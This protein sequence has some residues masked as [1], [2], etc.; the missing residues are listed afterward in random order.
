MGKYRKELTKQSYNIEDKSLFKQ[1]TLEMKL[2]EVI[3]S[4]TVISGKV[5]WNREKKNSRLTWTQVQS[6]FAN[7]LMRVKQV[8][9]LKELL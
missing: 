1:I 7:V 5:G 6:F 9:G 4:N 3:P 8:G 2:F